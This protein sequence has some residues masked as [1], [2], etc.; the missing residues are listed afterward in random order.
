MKPY[1]TFKF[2][3][4]PVR[5]MLTNKSWIF[6]P[7]PYWLSRCTS[8]AVGTVR[9]WKDQ[10]VIAL[11]NMSIEMSLLSMPDFSQRNQR[12]DSW[13]SISTTKINQLHC[14]TQV[15]VQCMALNGREP[16]SGGLILQTLNTLRIDCHH[17]DLRYR[18]RL[19]HELSCMWYNYEGPLGEH[20]T[21]FV[22]E[23]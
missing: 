14:R 22:S 5:W 19:P 13:H 18:K 21:H 4:Q 15:T 17:D 10:W 9:L 11:L 8:I 23:R 2:N 16:E 12:Q 7:V 20:L 1:A 3:I 6:D